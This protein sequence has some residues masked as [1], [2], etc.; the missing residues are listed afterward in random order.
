M[1]L[2]GS[3]LVHSQNTVN[4]LSFEHSQKTLT[5]LS[6]GEVWYWYCLQGNTTLDTDARR[7]CHGAGMKRTPVSTEADGRDREMMR[8]TLKWGWRP[9]L[10]LSR[11][12][13]LIL[14]LSHLSMFYLDGIGLRVYVCACLYVWG[15][16]AC[17]H[18]P[19]VSVSGLESVVV[20]GAIDSGA[21]GGGRAVVK[22]GGQVFWWWAFVIR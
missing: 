19:V 8:T 3:V 2:P 17:V 9:H 13:M 20:C 4:R 10:C 14:L 7:A 6:I 11:L 5:P 18:V 16:C 15:V 12:M 1:N 21:V 22:P